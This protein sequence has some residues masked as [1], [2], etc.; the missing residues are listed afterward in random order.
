MIDPMRKAGRPLVERSWRVLGE[1][2]ERGKIAATGV[3]SEPNTLV[4]RIGDESVKMSRDAFA[5]FAEAVKG[6]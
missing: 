4:L 6:A 3:E 5:A 2:Y 1:G